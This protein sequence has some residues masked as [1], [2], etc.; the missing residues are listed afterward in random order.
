MACQSRTTGITTNYLVDLTDVSFAPAED[1]MCAMSALAGERPTERQLCNDQDCPFY[2][3]SE[4]GEVNF[5]TVELSRNIMIR[6][7][8]VAW[9]NCMQLLFEH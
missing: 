5:L 6:H 9:H 8:S 1:A 4:F 7:G 3:P 2:Q